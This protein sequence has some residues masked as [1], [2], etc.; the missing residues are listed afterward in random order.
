MTTGMDVPPAPNDH[1]IFSKGH[2]SPLLY[3]MFKAAGAITDEELV[4]GFR[5]FGS[6]LQGHATPVLPWVDVVT[7]SLGQGLLY[8][9][10][11]RWPGGAWTSCR[12]RC[13]CCAETNLTAIITPPRYA[14]STRVAARKAYGDAL[15][16]SARG[17]RWS[18][19]T[20]RSATPPTWESSP[21]STRT[22]AS[23]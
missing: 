14:I 18:P 9:C 7:G 20:A 11:P 1:V 23:R 4:T 5:R 8:G 2:A 6:R 16:H 17:P 12:T 10:G 21:P 13:G 3:A 15:S 22:G 19:W